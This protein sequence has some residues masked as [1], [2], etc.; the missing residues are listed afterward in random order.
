[1]IVIYHGVM[2]PQICIQFNDFSYSNIEADAIADS[3]TKSKVVSAI[4]QQYY[5]HDNNEIIMQKT[6]DFQEIRIQELMV[7]RERLWSLVGVQMQKSLVSNE[8]KLSIW[9]KLWDR[10]NKRDKK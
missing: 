1:M 9:G 8:A 4:V 6:L 3:K 7:E 10:I 5:S 2:S